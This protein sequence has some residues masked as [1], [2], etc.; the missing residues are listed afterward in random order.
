[1]IINSL[2][3][4]AMLPSPALGLLP[5]IHDAEVEDVPVVDGAA[6]LPQAGGAKGRVF[7]NQMPTPIVLPA[8]GK[9]PARKMQQGDI[10]GSDGRL[11]YQVRNKAGTTS[12]YP[13]SF[14]RTVYN[15]SFTGTTF[16]IGNTFELDRLFY[17]RLFGNNTSAVWSVIFEIGMRSNSTAPAFELTM[18]AVLTSGSKTVQITDP[19]LGEV[20]YRM[21]VTG[22]GIP[23]GLDGTTYVRSIDLAA[24]TLVLSRAATASGTR[25]LTFRAPVGPNI[26]SFTWLPPML[27]EQIHLT[28]M[29]SMNAL[30]I[31]LKNW[32][33][34]ERTLPDGTTIADPYRNDLG[35]EGYAK[36]YDKAVAAPLDSLPEGY[37]FM[38][39]VRIGQFDVEDN[40]ADPKGCAAYVVRAGDDP[41]DGEGAG[42]N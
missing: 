30:G 25:A 16:P 37:E 9:W 29:K 33:E 24:K 31:W 14:E 7:K 35:F 32:G 41:E 22:T 10:F 42:L 2:K 3:E 20:A 34:K 4:V 19:Q 18:N 21:V 38:L 6:A 27:E 11:Y 15:F 23:V 5:A 8:T 40:V 26:E 36:V 17:F 28:E 1:M 39:R 12:F 13:E